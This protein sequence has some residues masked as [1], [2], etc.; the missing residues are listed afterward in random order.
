MTRE[1]LIAL[2]R[3]K[4]DDVNEPYLVEDETFEHYADEAVLEAARRSRIKIDNSIVITVVAGTAEYDIP[5]NVILIRRAKM[6]NGYQNLMFT[7]YQEMDDC[8][9]G[10]EEYTGEPTHIIADSSSGK[11]QLHPIPDT[12]DVLKLICIVDPVLGDDLDIPLRFHNGLIDW[13]AY[14]FYG[15]QDADISNGQREQYHYG[16][17][18][19][20]FGTR[21]SAQNE[22]F[23]SRNL[24][25][26]NSDGAY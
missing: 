16:R 25:F 13:L 21:S 2:T 9:T 22:L 24:P 8:V 5:S 14:R 1:E 10:W 17:F 7:G 4:V 6:T 19:E 11:V 12:N 3:V 23:D 26:Y 20:E 18:E 15:I